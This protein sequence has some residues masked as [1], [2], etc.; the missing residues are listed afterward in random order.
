MH[1]AKSW[2]R[3]PYIF[4]CSFHA[5]HTIAFG[6]GQLCFFVALYISS[7]ICLSCLCTTMH[8]GR[9]QRSDCQYLRSIYP[10]VLFASHRVDIPAVCDL[11]AAES[12]C[13]RAVISPSGSVTFTTCQRA[14]NSRTLCNVIFHISL[15]AS[16]LD[17]V[18]ESPV[19]PANQTV[20]PLL[21]PDAPYSMGVTGSPAPNTIAS[22]PEARSESRHPSRSTA[23]T[24]I[25]R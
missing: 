15:H 12:I 11:I 18:S 21:A 20:H 22:T 13:W 25:T 3:V 5:R 4:I 16:I 9:R 23:N 7:V 24:R 6:L 1:G 19:C 14:A 17:H 10:N 2:I 8:L